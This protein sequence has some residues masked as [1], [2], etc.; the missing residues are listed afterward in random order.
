[1]EE[2]K[3]EVNKLEMLPLVCVQKIPNYIFCV[4]FK[5]ALITLQHYMGLVPLHTIT[6]IGILVLKILVS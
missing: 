2:L 6:V 4:L 5:N 3:R 1:M